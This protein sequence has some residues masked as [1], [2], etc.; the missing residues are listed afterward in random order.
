MIRF[1]KEMVRFEEEMVEWEKDDNMNGRMQ[2]PKFLS[3]LVQGHSRPVKNNK[4]HSRQMQRSKK[5]AGE[6]IGVKVTKRP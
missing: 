5:G 4:K 3:S 1:E 2:K 6:V